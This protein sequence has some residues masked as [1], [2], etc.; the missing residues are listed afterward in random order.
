MALALESE[1]KEK[2]V[3]VMIMYYGIGTGET[4]CHLRHIEKEKRNIMFSYL[5]NPFPRMNIILRD[6]GRKMI[7]YHSGGTVI[8][9]QKVKRSKGHK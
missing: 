7:I 4:P 3:S 5:G 1:T 6:R 2:E 9:F 8:D